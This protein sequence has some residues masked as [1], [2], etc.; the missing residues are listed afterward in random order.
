MGVIHAVPC[1]LR[2]RNQAL[3]HFPD[4]TGLV[5]VYK[6]E[7]SSMENMNSALRRMWEILRISLKKMRDHKASQKNEGTYK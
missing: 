1:A 4:S 3:N 6:K 5:F 2:S 7:Y